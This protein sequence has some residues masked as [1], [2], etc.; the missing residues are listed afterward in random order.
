MPPVHRGIGMVFEDLALWPHMRIEQ[1]LDFVLKGMRLG[2]HDRR[3]RVGEL[4][5]L[6]RLDNRR[7]AYPHELSGGEKQRLAIARALATSP[8]ILLLDEPL[9]GL[10]TE[11]RDRMLSEILQL[12]RSLDVTAVYVT[13]LK[14]E[15][16]VIA[17]RIVNMREGKVT[18]SHD[19]NT[20]NGIHQVTF[21]ETETAVESEGIT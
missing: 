20:R 14:H 19:V 4:I 2:R 18:D 10:D 21:P 5:E 17:D 16:V 9:K 3:Q 1:H 15:A 13:H 8:A 11:L 6:C 12:R 7:R